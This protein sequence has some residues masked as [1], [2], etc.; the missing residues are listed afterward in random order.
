MGVVPLV[1]VCVLLWGLSVEASPNPIITL[2]VLAA[3]GIVLWFGWSSIRRNIGTK[4][5]GGLLALCLGIILGLFVLEIAVGIALRLSVVL[6]PLFIVALP[7]VVY[8]LLFR[9]PFK[10]RFERARAERRHF[11]S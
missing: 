4:L 7:L 6:F 8:D 3:C 11:R 9:S 10:G 2:V 1:I 5:F